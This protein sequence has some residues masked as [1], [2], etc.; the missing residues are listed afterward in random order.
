MKKDKIIVNIT[1]GF[2]CFILFL[3]LF[4]QFKVVNR[5]DI[6][7]LEAK[8]ESEL[9]AE[10]AEWKTKYEEVT[11]QST[12]IY[13]KI[14]EY[15]EETKTDAEKQQL[16]ESEISE[17][18]KKLGKTD[19]VG[20]GIEITIIE[21]DDAEAGI[22]ALDLTL[23][24]NALRAAGAEAISI[25]EQRIV[26]MTDIVDINSIDNPIIKVNGEYIR[27][28]YIIKAIGNSS[29]LESAVIGSNGKADELNALGHKVTINRKDLVEIQ[30][31]SGEISTKHMK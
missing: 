3:A 23:I 20:Q 8:G 28:P 27:S 13:D 25:N 24:V 21:E 18:N 12:E 1:V 5:T 15:Q 9:K 2:T 16:L 26:A 30:K 17:L 14:A 19:V 10:L 4:M 31:Y 11:T 22:E 6:S 29:Y 7:E